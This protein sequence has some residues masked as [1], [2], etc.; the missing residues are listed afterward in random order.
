MQ[1]GLSRATV[2]ETVALIRSDLWRYASGASLKSL[3]WCYVTSPGLAYSL[4]MRLCAYLRQRPLFKFSVYP[5]VKL[6]LRH[7]KYKYGIDI[8]ETTRIG[9]G[10]FIGHFG[11]IIVNSAAVL[12]KNCNLSQGVTIGTANRGERAGDPTIGDNVYIGPGAK[13]VGAVRVGNNVAIGANCVVTKDLPDNA[14]A[15][16][17]PARIAS[18]KGSAGYVNF[19]D[20]E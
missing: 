10:L 15:V 13:V 4:C 19:T 3:L 16:G 5:F 8:H 6:L 9:P 14:V 20:Y 12:G 7:H 11:G 1:C 17:V 18:F 2:T